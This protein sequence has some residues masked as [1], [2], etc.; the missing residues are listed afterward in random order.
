MMKIWVSNFNVQNLYFSKME[1]ENLSQ[2]FNFTSK[3]QREE[4]IWKII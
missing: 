4:N 3:K 1:K 2:Q